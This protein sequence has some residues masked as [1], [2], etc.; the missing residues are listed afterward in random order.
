MLIN[1]VYVARVASTIQQV[2]LPKVAA[3]AE[4]REPVQRVERYA[5]RENIDNGLPYTPWKM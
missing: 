3:Y 1:E 5:L 4:S 2:S